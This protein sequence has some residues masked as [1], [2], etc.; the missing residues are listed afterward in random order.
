MLLGTLLMIGLLCAPVLGQESVR[1]DAQIPG[2]WVRGAGFQVQLVYS[3]GLQGAELEAWQLTPAALELNGSPLGERSN[4]A[5]IP[6]AAGDFIQLNLELSSYLKGQSGFQ[7]KLAK[8]KQTPQQV[9]CFE[10]VKEGTD[11]M[12]MEAG[13]LSA[14]LVLMNTL[15]GEMLFGLW[16]EVA[17]NHVRNWLDLVH[18]KFYDGVQFHRVSP[19]FMIQG[20]CP[21]TRSDRSDQWGLGKGPRTLKLELNE[22][23]HEK[24]VLSMA[25]GP[26]P[27][28]GSS[29]FFVMTRTSPQLDGNYSTFGKLQEGFDVLAKIGNAEGKLNSGTISPERPQ[30]IFKAIVIRELIAK[31]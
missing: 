24:G 21:N 15:H 25:R 6:L 27:D 20:G 10:L 19:S 11:F 7:L 31:K 18:T 1:A 9:R 14:H 12:S 28:S 2:K 16:P 8:S 13:A 5:R 22:R 30:R 26:E 3:A 4:Q 29:Q 23:K 17:P